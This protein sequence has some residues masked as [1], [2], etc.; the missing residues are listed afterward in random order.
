MNDNL[1]LASP[2]W[3]R[4][5]DQ[6]LRRAI[7]LAKIQGRKTYDLLAARHEE[8][9]TKI[10]PPSI[11]LYARHCILIAPNGKDLWQ[12]WDGQRIIDLVADPRLY[13]FCTL[14]DQRYRKHLNLGPLSRNIPLLKARASHAC[15]QFEKIRNNLA[16]KAFLF[17][18]NGGGMGNPQPLEEMQQMHDAALDFSMLALMELN[19]RMDGFVG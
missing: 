14:Y 4:F 15:S 13:W 5:T 10:P 18:V 7:T 11:D 9:G 2:D 8:Q 19:A 12:Q 1:L 16:V 17:S 3:T 6:E